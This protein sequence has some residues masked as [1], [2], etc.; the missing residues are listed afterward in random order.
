MHRFA[1]KTLPLAIQRIMLEKLCKTKCCTTRCGT[2][3]AW[4]G[5][6]HPSETMSQYLISVT[7][8]LGGKFRPR[9]IIRAIDPELRQIEGRKCDH[10]YP[11]GSLCLYYHP[12]GEWGPHMLLANTII[13]WASRWL[14]FYELW[15]ATDGIW[16]GGGIHPGSNAIKERDPLATQISEDNT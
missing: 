8:K 7:L 1:P 11:D 15:L 13:P 4:E 16:L 6:V 14:Y 3:L 10:L 9:P 2:S 12:A 5:W